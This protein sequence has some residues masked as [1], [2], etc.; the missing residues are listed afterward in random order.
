[1]T[2]P[3]AP[4]APGTPVVPADVLTPVEQAAIATPPAP[5]EADDASH[6]ISEASRILREKALAQPR[7]E[8]GKFAA[9]AGESPVAEPAPAAEAVPPADGAPAPEPA[10][11]AAEAVEPKVFVLKGE[12]QR[13]EQDIELDIADLPP[14]VVERLERNEKQGMRRK[15]YDAAKAKVAQMQADLDAAE[16]EWAVDPVG[17]ALNYVPPAKR[18]DLAHALLMEHWD[19]LAP[20]IQ[21]YWEDPVGRMQ[22]LND[23]K[24]GVTTRRSEV[25]TTVQAARAAA[26]VKSAVAGMVPDTAPDTVASEFYTSAI[27]LLQDKLARGQSFAPE[28][29]PE[30]LADHRRRFFGAAAGEPAALPP[31][32]PRLA[33]KPKPPTVAAG[34]SPTTVLTQDAIAAAARARTAALATA[35]QGAGAGAVQRPGP[36]ANATIE[37]ASAFL[38]A[39][40]R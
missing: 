15:E 32:R 25:V 35:K 6:S 4:V 8:T 16:T 17:V 37:Q 14:D 23:I 26:A 38:R 20:S 21:K 11:P 30:L 7:D 19:E 34:S 18:G 36:P 31:A 27:A 2:A 24:N 40:K 28:Q 22:A 1:M 13:G 9:P 3:I 33:V 29:V 12:A 39:Q 5:V 10:A